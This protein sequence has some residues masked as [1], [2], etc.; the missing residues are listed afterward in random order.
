ML[1]KAFQIGNGYEWRPATAGERLYSRLDG[2][3]YSVP[4]EHIKVGL[5][6]KSHRL[7]IALF[8]QNFASRLTNFTQCHTV[9]TLVHCCVWQARVSTYIQSIFYHL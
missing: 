8:K 5:R 4:F 1:H 2:G 7:L 3:Y 9:D 6:P